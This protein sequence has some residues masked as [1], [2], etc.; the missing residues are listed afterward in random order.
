MLG[1][2]DVKK[3]VLDALTL[4]D[5]KYSPQT[6]L[7]ERVFSGIAVNYRSDSYHTGHRFNLDIEGKSCFI[8]DIHGSREQLYGVIEM[9]CKKSKMNRI[10]IGP[11]LEKTGMDDFFLSRLFR[12]RLREGGPALEKMMSTNGKP[13][14][15]LYGGASPQDLRTESPE[16]K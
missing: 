6:V 9:I 16:E 11:S 7:V 5:F 13:N 3:N 15:L 2:V 1:V 14:L 8:G 10:V 4:H 12:H